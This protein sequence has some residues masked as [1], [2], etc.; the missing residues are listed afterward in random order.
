MQAVFASIIWGETEPK[1]NHKEAPVRGKTNKV[2]RRE[3]GHR[4]SP[5]FVKNGDGSLGL[6]RPISPA[7]GREGEGKVGE[8]KRGSGA[9]YRTLDGK[10][11]EL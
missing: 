2:E 8:W 5:W 9:S 10:R 7:W 4:S 11:P 6:R 3:W 1:K